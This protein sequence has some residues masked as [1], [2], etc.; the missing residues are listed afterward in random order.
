MTDAYL[1][2]GNGK[3]GASANWWNHV[4]AWFECMDKAL[5]DLPPGLS[6]SAACHGCAGI[7]VPIDP[8]KGF[9]DKFTAESYLKVL[10]SRWGSPEEIRTEISRFEFVST[11]KE[12]WRQLKEIK[13]EE[14]FEE[15]IFESD[16]LIARV[17][18]QARKEHPG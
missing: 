9:S 14:E 1:L 3:T 7:P 8:T 17:A 12:A 15:S 5:G 4:Q 2:A 6:P 18:L 10:R 11:A 16:S 13:W